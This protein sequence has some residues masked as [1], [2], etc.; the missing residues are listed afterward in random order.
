MSC[1]VVSCLVS[2]QDLRVH[3]A[4]PGVAAALGA[5]SRT[6]AREPGMPRTAGAGTEKRGKHEQKNEASFGKHEETRQLQGKQK[7]SEEEKKWTK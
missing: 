5:A 6:P 4:V 1:H 2:R 3:G 7:K